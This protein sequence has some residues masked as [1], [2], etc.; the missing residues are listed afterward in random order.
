[1]RL[2]LTHLPR[3]TAPT[4]LSLGVLSQNLARGA[5]SFFP[6][7]NTR[8]LLIS[9]AALR[10]AEDVLSSIVFK[11]IQARAWIAERQEKGPRK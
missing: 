5:G 1:M 7:M 11:I 2:E 6:V 8:L 4:H 9:D 10:L 3:V